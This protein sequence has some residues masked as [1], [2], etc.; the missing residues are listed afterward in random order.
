MVNSAKI[1]DRAK[2]LG[3]RQKD[4]AI[5]LGLRQSSVNLKINNAR[6]MLLEEAELIAQ[7]LQ[8]PDSDFADYFFSRQV[9]QC[10][11]RL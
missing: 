7:L 3:I 5:T 11:T 10:N 6:P 1:K 4:I 2:T 9:A 8:I